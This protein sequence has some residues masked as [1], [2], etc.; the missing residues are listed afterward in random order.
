[1][2]LLRKLTG[3]S[4]GAGGGASSG[5]EGGASR[6]GKE[7]PAPRPGSGSGSGKAR[8]CDERRSPRASLRLSLPSSAAA[9]VPKAPAA[10]ALWRG[11]ESRSAI[12]ADMA[13][14]L[15]HVF[16][17]SKAQWPGG[18]DWRV[19][20]GARRAA[21][22]RDR[23]QVLRVLRGRELLFSE[24]ASQR[25]GRELCCPDLDQGK[26]VVRFFVSSTFT[27][28][29][30]ERDLFYAACAPHLRRLCEREGLEFQVSEMRWGISDLLTV[31]HK[32]SKLCMDELE[33]CKAD[34]AAINF[35]GVLGNKYGYRPFP[36][37]IDPTLFARLRSRVP[38][39]AQGPAGQLLE[40][41]Y[42]LDENEDVM[43]LL[44]V[45]DNIPGYRPSDSKSAQY[46][47]WWNECF[48]PMQ[49]AL[50]SAALAVAAEAGDP[51]LAR[52]FVESVTTEEMRH[53]FCLDSG[54]SAGGDGKVP[55]TL[56]IVREI[57]G[58]FQN[59]AYKDW[60]WKDKREDS[61]ALA[62][63][64]GLKKEMGARAWSVKDFRVPW[65]EGG[66]DPLKHA[67]HAQY[68]RDVLTA[69]THE[70][71]RSISKVRT[72]VRDDVFAEA[73]AH[74][75]HALDNAQGFVRPDDLLES[76]LASVAEQ[77]RR[78]AAPPAGERP[79]SPCAVLVDGRPGTGKTS[80]MA[81]AVIE[82][83]RAGGRH[84]ESGGA[85]GV[86][87]VRFIGATP[88]S[89]D[90][91]ALLRG[92][93]RQ[94]RR[95]LR[96]AS[97]CAKGHV[98]GERVCRVEQACGVCDRQVPLGKMAAH[99]D[100][101]SWWECPKCAES[102]AYCKEGHS[103]RETPCAA[104]SNSC[105]TCDRDLPK[106]R[107]IAGHCEECDWDVCVKCNSLSERNVDVLAR[108]FLS[109]LESLATQEPVLLV[110][111]SL[112][113]VHGIKESRLQWLPAE[114][115]RNV[116]LLVSTHPDTG[117]HQRVRDR[118]RLDEQAEQQQQQQ[119]VLINVPVLSN[120]AAVLDEWLA[121]R[122]RKLA[123]AQREAVL[124]TV[125]RLGEPTYLDLRVLLGEAMRWRSFQEV[126]AAW[127]ETTD[128]IEALMDRLEQE[129]SPEL[130]KMSLSLL[131]LS[132]EGLS[133]LELED[134]LSLD[135]E[136]LTEAFQWW[137]PPV[138]RV[139][140][141]L[142]TWLLSELK[143]YLG[144]SNKW[145]HAQFTELTARRYLGKDAEGQA[146]RQ[147]VHELLSATFSRGVSRKAYSETLYHLCLSKQYAK[148]AAKLLD[149]DWLLG[150]LQAGVPSYAIRGDAQR[151][152]AGKLGRD[153]DLVLNALA[154]AQVA[155]DN[156]P[157]E[158][159]SQ[160]LG[161]LPA[162]H[163]TYRHVRD[164]Y[165]ADFSWLRPV[166]PGALTPADDPLIRTLFGEDVCLGLAL[167]AERNLLVRAGF[168]GRIRVLDTVSGQVTKT[169]FGHEDEVRALAL[170]GNLLL[171]GS[172]DLTAIVWDL[173]RGEEVK[174][175]GGQ[176]SLVSAVAVGK[177]L[178]ATGVKAGWVSVYDRAKLER[179]AELKLENEL[180]ALAL[181]GKSASL[182]ASSGSKVVVFETASGRFA[183]R[184]VLEAHSQRVS[185]LAAS[186]NGTLVSGAR[187]TLVCVW[188]LASGGKLLHK[189]K[190]HSD[191]V[192]A[193]SIQ[194]DLVVSAGGSDGSAAGSSVHVW[195]LQTGTCKTVL[196]G[197]TSEVLACVHSGST[198]FSGGADQTIKQW[199][200]QRSKELE[201]GDVDEDDGVDD[202]HDSVSCAAVHSGLDN[203]VLLGYNSGTVRFFNAANGKR[204]KTISDDEGGG[205]DDDDES[206]EEPIDEVAFHRHE[207]KD[208]A[209]WCGP[210][211]S[212]SV[213]DATT[214]AR[215]AELKGHQGR[216]NAFVVDGDK[217]VTGS[218]DGV[219]RLF[220]LKGELLQQL[221]GHKKKV[222]CV[223]FEQASGTVASGSDDNTLKLWTITKAPKC[224]QTFRKNFEED[225][226]VAPTAAAQRPSPV[227]AIKSLVGLKKPGQDEREKATASCVAIA[228]RYV[229]AGWDDWDVTVYDR[230][231]TVL[232]RRLV[233]HSEELC[234]VT[235]HT[236]ALDGTVLIS[237]SL[238]ETLT[239]DVESGLIIDHSAQG[240]EPLRFTGGDVAVVREALHVSLPGVQVGFTTD[241]FIDDTALGSD[242][243][244]AV[245]AGEGC[246][247]LSCN[248]DDNRDDAAATDDDDTDDDNDGGGGDDDDDDDAA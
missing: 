140:P 35:V 234:S 93:C 132:R 80:L 3:G 64:E 73:Q 23:E 52:P 171:S 231:K 221:K 68:L 96:H 29:K 123:P 32:T 128:V 79:A 41:W 166:G 36:S 47:R 97:R 124:A 245:A 90:E 43:A 27:D 238:N 34:S 141:L 98:L 229:V 145:L 28:T 99:C 44:S 38:G 136:V 85:S 147:R 188:D 37:E 162:S 215:V 222:V 95:L 115:L 103:L 72:F 126:P 237:R 31:Q 114:P 118:L 54:G 26:R 116:T 18:K 2:E 150:A 111:D 218:D 92:L 121:A 7:A 5:G 39:G 78:A 239:W 131:T 176:R 135:D 138:V 120:A 49:A 204:V 151:Y 246:I 248:N 60:L 105:D 25:D 53:G 159:L 62:L 167:D 153:A 46:S 212:V 181:D 19:S 86:L 89:R 242:S 170:D 91:A 220:N 152:G 199:D 108:V 146:T 57:E 6:S 129:H 184:F 233:G 175:F 179:V 12:V 8:A 185:C 66:I 71:E 76:L 9:H 133:Q 50:R 139:P 178:L 16:G 15:Q 61:E 42:R 209:L 183:R 224:L 69:W 191:Q 244:L 208:Y 168:G 195:S 101:C 110:L 226:G 189:L 216:V 106:G 210:A 130:T 84:S 227:S 48:E 196:Q 4:R 30:H 119:E 180:W 165:N 75:A 40:Q 33:R 157:R 21:E 122:R 22:R 10:G 125:A 24:S 144:G 155:L 214:F 240:D 65:R 82:R 45:T 232:L 56:L 202:Y 58:E 182:A 117:L 161:R 213:R 201:E 223:A 127:R 225:P 104:Y 160:L 156:D 235:L 17:A 83:A 243:L 190:G 51:P 55:N 192:N 205:E 219:I 187:D 228:G 198:V 230:A 217:V 67:E 74:L 172:D 154:K 112:E 59:G 20:G 164:S 109:L 63:L 143:E 13:A 137:L 247:I 158:L 236:S 193:V 241:Q 100:R 197:H 211:W 200:L 70:A 174:R 203:L 194:G 148:A 177:A 94:L 1:M 77:Q 134:A 11:A 173:E 102:V 149:V 186:G 113:Q 169:L 81:K 142:V 14:K 163:P 207:G 87:L 88:E 206:R 107:V